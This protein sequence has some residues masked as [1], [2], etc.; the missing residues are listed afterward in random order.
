MIDRKKTAQDIAEELAALTGRLDA[1]NDD[2]L[3][4]WAGTY[5]LDANHQPVKASTLEW[6][7]WFEDTGN[8]RVAETF[9]EHYRISTVFLGIDHA[10]G[11]G[12]PLL[13][14]TMVFPLK[15]IDMKTGRH[16]YNED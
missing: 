2:P 8:R 14:E 9:T 16:S 13:Y 7:R 11:K 6:G 12:P 5:I 10:W 15:V 4:S 3:G 1:F